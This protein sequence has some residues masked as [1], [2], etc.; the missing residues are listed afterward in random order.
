MPKLSDFRPQEEN[1]NKHTQ[2]G[3]GMLGKSISERGFIGAITAAADGEVFD[4][5]ARLETVYDR[6]GDVEPIVVDADGTRPVIVRRTDIKTAKDPKAIKL[7]IEAN[8]IAQVNLDVDVDILRRI[9]EDQ[10]IDISDLYFDDEL[11]KLFEGETEE[12]EEDP[13]SFDQLSGNSDI[14]IAYLKWDKK[15]IALSEDELELLNSQY[16]EYVKEHG[17]S[18]GFVRWMCG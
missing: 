1:S 13:L 8:R 6:F 5:S 2:R 12:N 11:E 15:T 4:G 9:D 3:M 10:T 7:A 17:A 16:N 14:P 18:F